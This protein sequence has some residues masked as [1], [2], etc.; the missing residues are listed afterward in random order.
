MTGL[1]GGRLARLVAGQLRTPS[2]LGGRLIAWVMNRFNRGMHVAAA[3]ALAP[4][5]ADRVLE[6]GFGGATLLEELLR[7]VPEGS[8]TG[9]ELSET[10]LKGARHRLRR[11]IGR[12]RLALHEGTVDRLP[13]P[14]G[15]F[16]RVVSL[17]TIYFWS[18]AGRGLRELRRVLAPGGRLLLGYGDLDAMAAMP[19]TA[20]GFRLYQADEVEGLLRSA[21]FEAVVSRRHG[22]GRDAFVLTEAGTP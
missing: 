7:R 13:F 15:A 22:R 12:G 17:N 8:V 16:D 3:A 14:D 6:V 18:D 19:F 1:R 4:G 5:R 2:G 10:M 9:L 11:E 20:H 21:G